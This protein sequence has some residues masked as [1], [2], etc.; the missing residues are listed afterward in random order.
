MVVSVADGT[1]SFCMLLLVWS[2]WFINQLLCL[3]IDACVLSLQSAGKRMDL[4]LVQQGS[5]L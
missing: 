2:A 1:S 3:C 5:K 4:K